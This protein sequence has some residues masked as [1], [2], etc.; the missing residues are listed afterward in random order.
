MCF[1]ASIKAGITHY[2]FGAPSE[3]HMEP[4]L[5]VSEVIKYSHTNL[6]IS[7]GILAE[8]CKRQIAEARSVQG[9]IAQ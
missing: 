9:H 5:T 4:F 7:Y 3:A 2:I 1:S 6:D 8:E